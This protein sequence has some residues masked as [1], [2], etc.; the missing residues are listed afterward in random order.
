M[1]NIV[2]RSCTNIFLFLFFL[3]LISLTACTTM[4]VPDWVKGK[5]EHYTNKTYLLGHGVG[6]NQEVAEDNASRK[7]TQQFKSVSETAELSSQT[8]II[9]NQIEFEKTWLNTDTSQHH[10]LA[11]IS[12]DKVASFIQGKMLALDELT[13]QFFEQAK[14]TDDLLEQTSYI[15]SA[16]NAQNRR[17]KL[18]SILE[19]ITKEYDIQ[20]SYNVDR[21]S[22]IRDKLLTRINLQIDISQDKLGELDTIIKNS[23][24]K[25]GFVRTNSKPSQNHLLVELKLE[26]S[27]I[28]DSAGELLMQGV[29][30]TSIQHKGDETLRGTHQWTF[31][32]TATNHEML[33]SKSRD[34]LITQLNANLKQVIMD[35]MI[36][37]YDTESVIPNQD[38]VDFDMPEFNQTNDDNVADS[39]IKKIET[40][41]EKVK[42][43]LYKGKPAD[44]ENTN[45]AI[46]SDVSDKPK[47]IEIDT[48]TKP[49]A[50][51]ITAPID[52][53][54]TV[55]DDPISTLPPLAN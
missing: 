49:D 39:K 14:Q 3:G 27:P 19:I 32:V 29:L 43:D 25:A 30:T 22:K 17:I 28:P 51:P 42:I 2:T 33:I 31:N 1:I 6:Q 15:N 55:I 24:N 8:N 13:Y 48:S 12:R 10:V 18:K 52:N 47:S 9:F 23:L 46:I 34:I 5:S 40:T 54:T 53:S 44:T 11:Y 21:L 35:M 16:I 36:I 20:N 45:T 4:Y 50:K 37:E 26:E 38:H 7:I 41:A